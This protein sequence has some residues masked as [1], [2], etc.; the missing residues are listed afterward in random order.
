MSV[1]RTEPFLYYSLL[2]FFAYLVEKIFAV[3]L[4]KEKKGH[5]SFFCPP[6]IFIIWLF[7]QKKK[8]LSFVRFWLELVQK[9]VARGIFF[10]LP[11][12]L[13]LVLFSEKSFLQ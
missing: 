4:K 3:P 9:K 6:D 11:V 7:L 2:Y 10:K 1:W 12:P 5:I 13:F 8:K